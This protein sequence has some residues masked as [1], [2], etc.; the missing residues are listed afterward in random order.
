MEHFFLWG[1]EGFICDYVPET[2]HMRLGDEKDSFAR[3]DS[4][5]DCSWNGTR[6]IMQGGFH[7]E[8]VLEMKHV[9]V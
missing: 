2:K 9:S 4:L 1:G 8:T 6:V 7:C 3:G 5:R